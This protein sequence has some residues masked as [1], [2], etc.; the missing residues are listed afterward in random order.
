MS[1]NSGISSF[2]YYRGHSPS[3]SFFGASHADRFLNESLDDD[4]RAAS[5]GSS[6]ASSSLATAELR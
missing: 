2:N 1:I 3:G 5:I 4:A 6:I